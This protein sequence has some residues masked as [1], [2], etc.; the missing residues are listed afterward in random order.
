MS[1][2]TILQEARIIVSFSPSTLSVFLSSR[3]H[4]S[5]LTFLRDVL[6]VA[7]SL[8]CT[9]E[10][11]S[12]CAGVR[13]LWCVLQFRTLKQS[14]VPAGGRDP[15]AECRWRDHWDILA[16]TDLPLSLSLFPLFHVFSLSLALS[17]SP[18]IFT[19]FSVFASLSISISQHIFICKP[20]P[21]PSTAFFHRA[22][23]VPSRC[24][25]GS[26]SCVGSVATCGRSFHQTWP[27]RCSARCCQRHYSCW[28]E[29]MH[30]PVLRTK[31]TCKSGTLSCTAVALKKIFTSEI[32]SL[33]AIWIILVIWQYCNITVF[34]Q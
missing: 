22:S 7:P 27:R 11:V 12:V 30:G 3:T 13:L 19:S 8:L 10:R 16:L 5:W 21:L 34:L 28:C 15:G 6:P 18:S 17:F 1:F 9:C 23:A 26:T 29:D 20:P 4:L 25:C 33:S 31:D 32:L 24:R 2:P 14:K